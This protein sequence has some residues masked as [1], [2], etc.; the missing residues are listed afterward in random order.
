MEIAALNRQQ[1]DFSRRVVIAGIA[2]IVMFYLGWKISEAQHLHVPAEHAVATAVTT[3]AATA[4]G[5]R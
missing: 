3:H 4:H 2:L 1:Q 5:A